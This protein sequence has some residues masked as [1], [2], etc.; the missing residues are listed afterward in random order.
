MKNKS[1]KKLWEIAN[2]HI[3]DGNMLF[4]KRPDIFLPNLWPSY[5]SRAKGCIV[6][7]I[8]GKKFFDVCMMGVGTNV[9]GYSNQEVNNAVKKAVDESNMSTLNSFHEVKLAK[10]LKKIHRWADKV[11][12][13]RTGGEANAIAIRIAR[14]ATKT[15][16]TPAEIFGDGYQRCPTRER[17]CR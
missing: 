6:W 16:Q 13:A 15:G 14:A 4:S 7:D 10:K 17:V 9:L 8:K 12:F 3:Q 2:S 5:Y 1:Y 11:K